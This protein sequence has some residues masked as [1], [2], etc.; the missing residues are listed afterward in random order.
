MHIVKVVKILTQAGEA[1]IKRADLMRA[2]WVKA[3]YLDDILAVLRQRG[4]LR[5]TGVRPVCYTYVSNGTPLPKMPPPPPEERLAVPSDIPV[6]PLLGREPGT[7]CAW[8][9]KEMPP[10]T[11]GRP[12]IYCSAGCRKAAGSADDRLLEILQR[13]QDPYTLNVTAHHLIAAD[14]ASRGFVTF[15][16]LMQAGEFGL[17][18]KHG[19]RIVRV[20]VQVARADGS[21]YTGGDHDILAV[22]HR[23]GRI[24]YAGLEK[25]DNKLD[26]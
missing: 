24:E 18:A 21:V 11:K 13:P 10:K 5:E 4:E 16:A 26:S 2:A 19:N 25:L 23:D 3:H 15:S 14:L 20:S 7:C 9:R 17:A 8:C 22:V 6:V 1:G 12:H